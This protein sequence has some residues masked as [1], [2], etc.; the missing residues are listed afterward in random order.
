MF[1]K[2]IKVSILIVLLIILAVIIIWI[3]GYQGQ[4]QIP[5]KNNNNDIKNN[6]VLST[7]TDDDIKKQE[8]RMKLNINWGKIKQIGT[9]Y[10]II[11]FFE[12]S[13]YEKDV[14]R[15]D[16]DS[17]HDK[18]IDKEHDED[19]NLKSSD[20]KISFNQDTVFEIEYY[21]KDYPDHKPYK[22]ITINNANVSDFHIGDGITIEYKGDF[23]DNN[24]T[25]KY[26]HKN[27]RISAEEFDKMSDTINRK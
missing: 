2:N 14:S 26:I 19:S 1:K 17:Q 4:K 23:N 11:T 10:L 5:I 9:D 27:E 18:N 6:V 21:P 20:K 24:L 15:D 22:V 8:E 25:A 7:I 3:F 16:Q 12:K 13:D